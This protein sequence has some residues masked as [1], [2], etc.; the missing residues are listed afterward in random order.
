MVYIQSVYVLN[1]FGPKGCLMVCRKESIALEYS[2]GLLA[3]SHDRK[4]SQTV[5]TAVMD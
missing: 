2:V 1:L 3:V 4:G 5:G